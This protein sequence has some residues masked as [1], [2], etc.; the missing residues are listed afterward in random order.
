LIVKFHQSLY[1]YFERKD[2]VYKC[3]ICDVR[4]PNEKEIE[5]VV[6]KKN[7]KV[8]FADDCPFF[9]KFYG[10][11]AGT[12]ITIIFSNRHIFLFEVRNM[13]GREIMNL[14]VVIDLF[15]LLVHL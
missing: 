3:S 12:W 8:Y 14:L 7:S 1:D 13:H 9:E 2:L 10:I 5:V 11:F 6:E 15:I 4:D